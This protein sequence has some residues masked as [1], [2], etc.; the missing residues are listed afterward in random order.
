MPISLKAPVEPGHHE[1][2]VLGEHFPSTR[3]DLGPALY[4]QA[5]PLNMDL[6]SSSRSYLD[7]VDQ[8]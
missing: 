7:V 5:E 2:V 6:W 1:L 4:G 8:P 3:L